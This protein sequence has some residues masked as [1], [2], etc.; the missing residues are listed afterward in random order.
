MSNLHQYVS[1]ELTKQPEHN[2]YRCCIIGFQFWLEMANN[3]VADLGVFRQNPPP[4]WAAP[5]TKKSIDRV[6]K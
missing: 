6:I 3:T 5:S 2:I 1:S 4:L